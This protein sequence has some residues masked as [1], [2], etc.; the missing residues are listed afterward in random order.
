MDG[1]EW[2]ASVGGIVEENIQMREL[3]EE[4]LARWI[5]AECREHEPTR[6][7]LI[8]AHAAGRQKV[9]TRCGIYVLMKG[10][11]VIY[12]GQSECVCRRIAE[13]VESG[14]DFDSYFVVECDRLDL[15]RLEHRIITI[16]RPPLNPIGGQR[17]GGALLP[18]KSVWFAQPKR[19]RIRRK[20][21]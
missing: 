16:L 5:E 10:A 1:P 8:A 9:D 13:H 14:K 7:R 2:A 3:T 18:I 19:K 11:S 17:Y 21:A 4:Q 20:A 15:T 12:V 6:Q